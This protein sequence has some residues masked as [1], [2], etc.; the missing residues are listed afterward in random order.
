MTE[1][2]KDIV[3]EATL[4]DSPGG[5][6]LR[7]RFSGPFAGRQV[8]WDATLIAMTP[9]QQRNYIEIGHATE[10]GIQL[11]VGLNVACIDLPTVRKT[12]MMIRQ[13]KRLRQGRHEYGQT[14]SGA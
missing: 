4:L 7:L 12:M 8:I 3:Q 6:Q 2:Q 10:N 5:D 13:Y 11:T 9:G 1:A 14:P